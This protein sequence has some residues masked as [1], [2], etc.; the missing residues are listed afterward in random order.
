MDEILLVK[1]AKTGDKSAFSQLY[2]NHRDRLYRYAYFRLGS[3]HDANDAVSACIVDAYTGI[4]TLRDERAF[5]SWLFSI[6]YRECCAVLRR[7]AVKA[8]EENIDDRSDIAVC[9]SSLAPE[10][11]EALGILDSMDRDIVLLSAV[12]GYN[13]SEIAGMLSLNPSTVRSRLSRALA[14]MRNFLE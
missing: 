4:C 6:L 3:E 1:Q 14:K 11:S 7:R 9:D 5:S 10:L 2:M 13:S 8:G 12:A